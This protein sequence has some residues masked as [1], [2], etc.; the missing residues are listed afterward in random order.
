MET[1]ES[2]LR[3][4]GSYPAWARVLV[5][6]GAAISVLTLLLAPRTSVE[7]TKASM[8]R[9]LVTAGHT[10]LFAS[11]N[12]GV[13]L[14]ADRPF[15]SNLVRLWISYP[16]AKGITLTEGNKFSATENAEILVPLDREST[17][18]IGESGTL[19][20]I[21][22]NPLFYGEKMTAIEVSLARK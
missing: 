21:P 11:Q 15:E 17:I 6:A 5:F 13:K 20:I 8:A 12:V 10:T 18:S 1:I 14:D 9:I 2:I 22:T 3:F 16:K 7:P 19:G 4:A